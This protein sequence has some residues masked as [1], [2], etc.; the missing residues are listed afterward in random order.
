M[1][2]TVFCCCRYEQA[3]IYFDQIQHSD[4]GGG[5]K[6]K[7]YAQLSRLYDNWDVLELHGAQDAA[8]RLKQ[9]MIAQNH[10]N[11]QSPHTTEY[12][13]EIFSNNG[14]VSSDCARLNFHLRA[15]E[16]LR[17]WIKEDEKDKG[18]PKRAVE[19]SKKAGVREGLA[20]LRPKTKK[21]LFQQ[22]PEASVSFF[23][24]GFLLE[25]KAEREYL[26]SKFDTGSLFLYRLLEWIS[27]YRLASRHGILA[28]LTESKWKAQFLEEQQ[29]TKDP[30]KDEVWLAKEY[31]KVRRYTMVIVN[32]H[33]TIFR[34]VAKVLQHRKACGFSIGIQV[35][36]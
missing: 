9:E 2:L 26:R 11:V 34:P 29:D 31:R 27:Q 13:A 7:I 5:N 25:A 19:S 32:S 33:P 3:A 4:F 12:V 16:C 20:R 22:D 10:K 6:A 28:N 17:E 15:L 23:H 24:V 8:G 35:E 36:K 1:Y 18:A 14:M 21:G 30:H